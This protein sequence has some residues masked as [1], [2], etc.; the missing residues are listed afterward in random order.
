[1]TTFKERIENHWLPIGIALVIA[2]VAITYGIVTALIIGPKDE[3]ISDLKDT[4]Q[5]QKEE[6]S[7]YKNIDVNKDVL[8]EKTVMEG[9]SIALFDNKVSVYLEEVNYE[10]TAVLVVSS[11]EQKPQT[12]EVELSNPQVEIDYGKKKFTFNLLDIRGNMIDFTI[13][14]LYND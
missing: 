5:E 11:S 14:N 4:I 9:E 1:M 2:S 3:K 6:L 12:V 8:S 13:S 10:D 7:N